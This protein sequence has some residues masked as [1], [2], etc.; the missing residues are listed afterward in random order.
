MKKFALSAVVLF[1]TLVCGAASAHAKTNES[2]SDK[3]S[4]LALGDQEYKKFDYGY[5]SFFWIPKMPQY[6]WSDTYLVVDDTL[7]VTFHLAY[8]KKVDG[9]SIFGAWD[10]YI[11]DK[12]VCDKCGGTASGLSQKP[13]NSY[14]LSVGKFAMTGEITHSDIVW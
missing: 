13:G 14:K 2:I 10:V 11:N 4:Y 6:T 8:A 3:P 5:T 1:A 12:L 7:T 9:D